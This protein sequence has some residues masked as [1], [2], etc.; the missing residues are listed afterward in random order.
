MDEYNVNLIRYRLEKANDELELAQHC[1]EV[2]KFS[3]SLNCSY[4]AIFHSAR[5]LLAIEKLDFKK[6]SGVISFFIKTYINKNLL[7]TELGEIIRTAERERNKSDYQDFYTVSKDEALEQLSKAELFITE[8]K[9]FLK[10][11]FSLSND[12]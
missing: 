7:N 12:M 2:N 10:T 9:K 4:Y 8:V 1:I 3:K 11:N 6:H 5:A